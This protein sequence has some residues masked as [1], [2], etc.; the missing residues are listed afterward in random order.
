MEPSLQQPSS[1][2]F[3]AGNGYA[4]QN[5]I[6]RALPRD[7]SAVLLPKLTAVNLKLQ[8]LL[9]EAGHPI[10]FCYFPN[11]CMISILT[12]M[13]DGKSIEVELAGRESFV[14]AP[15]VVGFRTSGNRAVTQAEG[16]AYRIDRKTFVEVLR[17]SPQLNRLLARN[18][19]KT[20]FQVSQIAACNRLHEIEPRLARWLLMTQDRVRTDVLPLTHDFLS[21]MLGVNRSTVTIC[22]GMLQEAGLIEYRRGKVHVLDRQRLEEAS[23]ECY[24]TMKQQLQTWDAESVRKQES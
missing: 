21:Q 3:Q 7:E 19:Q 14:G 20:A 23:C 11:T 1:D 13:K 16:T 24:Q 8:S 2:Q 4:I 6:L 22:A 10:E 15:L 9:Q 18:A 12:L 17:R 5:E